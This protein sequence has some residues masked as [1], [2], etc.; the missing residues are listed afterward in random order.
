MNPEVPQ[1]GTCTYIHAKLAIVL[2]IGHN[3]STSEQGEV[4]IVMADG[5]NQQERSQLLAQITIAQTTL[6]EE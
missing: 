6:L 1:Y 5:W 2:F 3:F 4:Q